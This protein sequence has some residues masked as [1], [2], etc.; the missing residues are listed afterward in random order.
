M[1]LH[2]QP[3]H[4]A[5]ARSAP[6]RACE[7]CACTLSP[8]PVARVHPTI[9]KRT[10][11]AGDTTAVVPSEEMPLWQQQGA[12]TWV[13]VPGLCSRHHRCW[14]AGTD[15]K[16]HPE[17]GADG[18]TWRHLHTCRVTWYSWRR[19]SAAGSAS[20]AE[21]AGAGCRLL[22]LGLLESHEELEGRLGHR[23]W[24]M[25]GDVNLGARED[26]VLGALGIEGEARQRQVGG[27]PE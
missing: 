9:T 26:G 11:G 13:S 12:G 25:V 27:R 21:D 6:F 8:E 24:H 17:H 16:R 18:L 4:A 2:P 5:P 19:W 3:C 1:S 15:T 23:V 22:S 14:C 20:L 7:Q 10:T